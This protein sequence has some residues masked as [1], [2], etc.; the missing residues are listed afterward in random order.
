[1]TTT[2]LAATALKVAR[3]CHEVNRALCASQG[4]HTQLPFDEAPEWQQDSAI[5]GVFFHHNNPDAGPSNSHDSWMR[6]KL[7]NGWVYGATKDEDLQTHPCIVPFDQLP[8]AQQSKDFVFRQ[9]VH[10]VLEMLE[11][12]HEM[13][14]KRKEWVCDAVAAINKLAGVPD[15][16][17]TDVL[18]E[19][20]YETPPHVVVT[21]DEKMPPDL[22]AATNPSPT[23][24]IMKSILAEKSKYFEEAH[25][26]LKGIHIHVAEMARLKASKRYSKLLRQGEY[27]VEV[28]DHQWFL[29][30]TYL[31]VTSDDKDRRLS[32]EDN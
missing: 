2:L 27:M 8:T 15:T 18:T 17:V 31:K 12:K 21:E 25:F 14:T 7:D 20:P 19:E 11:T 30:D 22:E 32:H 9:I 5:L 6:E 1:M 28:A 29:G 4:D 26:E 3:I 16:K 23:D 24:I 10:S 13:P